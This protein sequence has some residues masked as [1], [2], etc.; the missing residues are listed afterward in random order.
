[1]LSIECKTQSMVLLITPSMHRDLA[2]QMMLTNQLGF[3]QAQA[4]AFSPPSSFR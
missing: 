4:Q 3:S 2:W 1:M